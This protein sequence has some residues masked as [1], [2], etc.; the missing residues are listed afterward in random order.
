MPRI[1]ARAVKRNGFTIPDDSDNIMIDDSGCDQSIININAFT[2]FTHTGI[3][4]EIGGATNDMHSVTPLEVVNDAYTLATCD[5]GTKVIFIVHQAMLD[6]DETQCEALLA[7]H[8]ARDH[9]VAVDNCAECH[10]DRHGKPGGQCI[11]TPE[12]EFRFAF[13]GRKCFFSI[14]KPTESDLKK[15]PHVSLTSSRPYDPVRKK[16]RRRHNHRQTPDVA[17][18]RACLGYPTLSTT[19]E[20]LANTTQ[21]ITTL[22]AESRE[23]MR[24]HTA[25][26]AHA[27]RP[28]RID[29]TLFSDTF[30]SGIVSI[31][32]FKMFQMFAYKKSEMDVIQLMKRESQ[33]SEKYED[34]I[35]DFGAPNKTVTDNARALIGTK[36]KSINRKYC[37]QTG[38]TSP[39]MQQ[40]NY[41]EGRGGN[42]KFALCKLLHMTPHAPPEYW[43]Y[44]AEFLDQARRLLSKP[45]LNGQSPLE[46]VTGSTTDISVFRFPWFSPVWYYD[47]TAS[48]PQDR[49]SPGF[50]LNVASNTGDGFSYVILPC[51]DIEDIPVDTAR[52][53]V[54]NIVRPRILTC[55][56][57]PST[58]LVEDQ[59]L[60]YNERG[61]EIFGDE[62]LATSDEAIEEELEEV[63][64]V[65]ER[66]I[67]SLLADDDQ[68]DSSEIRNRT[69][70]AQLDSRLTPIEE[71]PSTDEVPASIPTPQSHSSSDPVSST[72]EPVST[73]AT[74]SPSLTMTEEP[75]AKKQRLTPSSDP[76]AIPAVTQDYDSDDESVSDKNPPITI[77]PTSYDKDTGDFDEMAERVNAVFDDDEL[78]RDLDCITDHRTAGGVLELQ[79]K[80]KTGYSDEDDSDHL[81]GDLEWHPIGLLKDEDP[82]AVAM[83]LIRNDVGKTHTSIQRRW[84]RALL[85]SVRQT[86]RRR[87][88]V[89]DFFGGFTSSSFDPS[90]ENKT[91]SRSLSNKQRK[92][93]R[94]TEK[95]AARHKRKA[96]FKYGIE[97]PRNWQDI[98]RIDKAN[99]NTNWQDAVKK[100]V[101]AL[102][103]HGC[104]EFHD[105]KGFKPSDDF[106]YC[107]LHFV[108]EVK[109]DLRQKARLVCNGSTVDPKGLS[110]RA[111]V[112]KG[113]SVRLLD[114]I[115]EAQGLEVLCGDIGNAFI[116]ATTNEKVYTRVG[117]EFGEHAGKIAL[118]VK[119]LYGLTTSA[120]RF[121]TLFADFIRSIGF[122]PTRFDRDV[123]M[124]L[125]DD[126]T[127][128]DYICTH[129]D[130]FKVVAK[131]PIKWIDRIAGAFLIKEH[132]PRNY[133][134]GND[135]FYHDDHDV[136]TYGCKTYATEAI[137]KVE[138][139][140]GTIAKETT[141][142]P[143]TD[144]HPEMDQSPLLDLDGH[145]KFQMLLGMLQWLMAIGRP[146]LSQVVACL[147]RFGA[148][149]REYH[150]DLAVRCFGFIKQVPNPVIAIDSRPL[151]IDR[152][153]PDFNA[154]IPDFLQDYPDAKEEIASHFPLAFG[155]VM[156]TAILVDADH[157]HDKATRRSLT[158]LL[159]FVGSTPVLWLS[160]RQG[161][162]ASSTYAAEFSALR[163]ATEEA[164]GL[165]YMLRCLGCNVPTDGSCPTKIFGDNLSVIQNAQNPAAD[166]SKKHV[167]ISFH[168]VREAV[169]AGIVEPYWLQGQWNLSDIMTKQ[170][171][172]TEF[173][174]HCDY[175]F[176]RPDFHIRTNNRLGE[177]YFDLN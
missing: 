35:I 5:D 107:H 37:I 41:A 171:P 134:L 90:P 19:E 72:E 28:H 165:R 108:Y 77:T 47:P 56:V 106:Q 137:A 155:P 110:T 80:Y 119:A 53:I 75:A 2:V 65:S 140:F 160:K 125:R 68:P 70:L 59:I 136:W 1:R 127:G 45:G 60:F 6:L 94:K 115:A 157:A 151:E 15:Y 87:K 4:Y 166:L 99:G 55:D 98:L 88:K 144:C 33:A 10:Q 71:E 48:F 66:D 86:I 101:A 69:S 78:E 117:N 141:P 158:G 64:D 156:E 83:Y 23:Y 79:V 14:S 74:H 177:E 57:P 143:T 25:A 146:D 109:T 154:L 62:E 32:G 44:A 92:R 103:Q 95:N 148:A 30:F 138:R 131:D 116:Q 118:I 93:F 167:A 18:W 67:S 84:A 113:I 29:D 9:S 161:S 174:N 132:G 51:K 147:N 128:Y 122:T 27:L 76:S 81:V 149:P 112:V 43:C 31:R 12:G 104:F 153:F 89:D 175:I 172:R 11:S 96:E 133:Y 169:A 39:Y 50:F 163:T 34:T 49:M 52:P 7:P 142:L 173:M 170:I 176:W 58:T 97:L 54:R 46:R 82:Y 111:T 40:Q 145:R 91:S 61:D 135:Y 159:A 168:T 17:K 130:D 120:E 124:R 123:W 21:M 85:R 126:K 20:T 8:Q 100:E 16:T 22:Q 150:L 63:R 114:L 73:N 24:S 105:S 164:I 3:F 162:I 26:R 38:Y 129:V 42:F 121:H 102:I 152:T 36:W 139:M 13:D